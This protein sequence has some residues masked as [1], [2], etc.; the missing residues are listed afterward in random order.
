MT[1]APARPGPLAHQVRISRVYAARDSD[2]LAELYDDWA[3]DY[4]GD[5]A[6]AGYVAPNMAADVVARHVPRQEPVLDAGAGTGLVGMALRQ[7]GYGALTA[8]D[9]SAGMLQRARATGAYQEHLHADL[10]EP[11]DL[12]SDHF[13]GVISVGVFTYGHAPA[14]CLDELVRVT[15]PGGHVV[16]TMRS[17]FRD[18][19]PFGAK[20]DELEEAGR[21]ERV[22]ATPDFR[23]FG[24]GAANDLLRLWVYRL[25][26]R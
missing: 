9:V 19:S 15:R 18:A 3:A 1:S 23:C 24:A 12:P 4:D 14:S 26:T 10:G 16:F 5:L 22:L 2:E 20:V 21:W 17:E 6:L 13:G 8:L 25:T 11:L 7:L